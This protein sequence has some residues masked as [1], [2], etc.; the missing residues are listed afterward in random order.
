MQSGPSDFVAYYRSSQF[1]YRSSEKRADG[2]E[3]L[4][5]IRLMKN[6]RFDPGFTLIELMV[7]VAVAATVLTVGVP[8]FRELIKENRIATSANDFM[9][10]IH[11]ARSEAV[12]RGVRISLCKSA[13]LAD[14]TSSGGWEQG[15]MIFRDDGATVGTKETTEEILRVSGA[16]STGMTLRGNNNVQNRISFLASGFSGGTNGQLVLC[17]D[18]ISNFATD[19][20]KARVFIISTTG[21]PRLEKGDNSDVTVTSCSP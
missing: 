21:R 1:C 14:C 9:A 19:K 5:Y 8:S 12:T 16:M 20:A 7:T 11:M 18:R 17:D 10:A 15:W 13:N 2:T 3:S 4:L 6:Q